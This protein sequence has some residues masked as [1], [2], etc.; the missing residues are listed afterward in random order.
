MSANAP[1]GGLALAGTLR[2]FGAGVRIV[3]TPALVMPTSPPKQ[4]LVNNPDRI[5]W[6]V[7]NLSPYSGTI[8]F[9]DQMTLQSG[10]LLAGLGGF[11][12]MLVDEDGECVTYPLWGLSSVSGQ[13]WYLLEI[14]RA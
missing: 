4:I 3:E 2:K 6:V 13:S 7:M 14:M 10:L 12:A 8:A 11:A 5:F 1:P 9:N